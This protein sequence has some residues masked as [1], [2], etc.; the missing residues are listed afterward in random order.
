M[1]QILLFAAF[2]LLACEAVAKL[3]L[4]APPDTS[5]FSEAERKEI[6]AMDEHAGFDE[7]GRP[8]FLRSDLVSPVY[9][10]LPPRT[11]NNPAEFFKVAR[12]EGWLGHLSSPRLADANFSALSQ[13]YRSKRD[14]VLALAILDGELDERT[15]PRYSKTMAGNKQVMTALAASA[16]N[17]QER[18][19]RQREWMKK[20]G[21][22]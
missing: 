22:E 4:P 5:M 19:R 7:T 18:E 8:L 14:N 11:T 13:R 21:L 1:K 20:K 3:N 2:S 10:Q 9:K 6:G 12:L 17:E 16:K 15:I